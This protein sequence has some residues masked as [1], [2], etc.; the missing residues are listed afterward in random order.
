MHVPLVGAFVVVLAVCAAMGSRIGMATFFMMMSMNMEART[1]DARP[2]MPV[3]AKNRCP[4]ELERDDEH[5]EQGNEATHSADS[6]DFCTFS[7]RRSKPSS[8]TSR[9][10]D[11]MV[12]QPFIAYGIT[13]SLAIIKIFDVGA[14]FVI[15]MHFPDES[16]IRGRRRVMS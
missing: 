1:G 16:D 10:I 2:D 9:R 6:T 14:F 4:G 15:L 11:S 7:K 5:D 8:A 12:P 13:D 3:H